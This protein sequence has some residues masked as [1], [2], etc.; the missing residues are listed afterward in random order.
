MNEINFKNRIYHGLTTSWYKN[1]NKKS[2]YNWKN[3]Q[4]L[5][6]KLWNEDGCHFVL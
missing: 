1:G 4:L 6:L 5:S 3:S 2:V